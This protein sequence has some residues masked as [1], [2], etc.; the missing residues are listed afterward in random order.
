MKFY[1]K[2]EKIAQ[3]LLDSFKTPGL[4]PDALA[5]IYIECSDIPSAKWSYTNRIM[6]FLSGTCDARGF[7]QWQQVNRHVKKG[8]CSF[9]I[10]VPLNKT[11]ED[12]V[13]GELIHLLYGFKSCNVFGYEQTGGEPLPEEMHLKQS[14]DAYPFMKVAEK[15]GIPIITHDADNVGAKGY[16]AY[17][18][19]KHIDSVISLG[20]MNPATWAHELIHATEYRLDQLN[21]QS[22]QQLDNE[23]VAEQGGCVVLKLLGYETD[24]DVGGCYEY[25]NHYAKQNGVSLIDTAIKYLNRTCR[26]VAYILNE[27]EN[28]TAD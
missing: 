7:R 10:L 11:I 24:A 6:M 28:I 16:F 25:L 13:T 9:P 26:A 4:L 23:Y 19:T 17:D 15:W 8:G 2:A 5:S 3:T 12:N 22:G 20:V 14:F 27:L 18:K 1:G 21:S